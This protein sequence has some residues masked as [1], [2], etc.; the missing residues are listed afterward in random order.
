MTI[1][2]LST[3]RRQELK[4]Q[5]VRSRI[6]VVAMVAAV[7]LA[8]ACGGDGDSE[9]PSAEDVAP[10]DLTEIPVEA[11]PEE[12]PEPFIFRGGVLELEEDEPTNQEFIYVVEAGDSLAVIAEKFG[13]TTAE[14]QRLN[15]I[16]DPG[17]LRAGEELRV[18]VRPGTEEGRIAATPDGVEEDFSGPPPG[19]EYVIQPG[20]N[21]VD[22]GLRFGIGWQEIATY[23]RMS[24]FEA[25][26]LIVGATIIIPPPE[27]EEEPEPEPPG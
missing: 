17:L 12:L 20:D 10:L 18:P 9:I 22:I 1:A 4:E 25:N 3:L 7:S 19:E 15:G 2:V 8:A 23:N 21:L 26:F 13:V 16:A 24:D 27:E 6:G 11:L 14:L 5:R